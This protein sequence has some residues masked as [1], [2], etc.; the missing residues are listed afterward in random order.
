MYLGHDL[1]KWMYKDKDFFMGG[2]AV[3]CSHTWEGTTTRGEGGGVILPSM[4]PI[5]AKLLNPI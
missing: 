2:N 3:Y 5:S 1:Y 4:T